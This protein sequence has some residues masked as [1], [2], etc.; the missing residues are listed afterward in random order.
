MFAGFLGWTLDAFDYFL[1]VYCLTVIGREFHRSDAEMAATITATLMFRPLGA[2]LFGL[3]S[4][5]Y[6]R[7]LP[8]IANLV[9]YSAAEVA[10]AFAGSYRTFLILRALFGIGMGGMWGTGASL[11]MEKVPPRLRG[12][13][14]G[15][16]QQGYALGNLLAALAYFFFV[17]RFG[18]RPLF[19]IGGL[20]ALLAIFVRTQIRESEVWEET[21]AATWGHL[22]RSLWANWKVFLYMT[23]LMTFMN[24]SSHGTQDMYPTFLQR[25]WHFD[26]S[27]RSIFSAIASVGALIGG[28]CFGWY[29]D[30]KG[31]RR[32]IVTALLLA[33]AIIPLWTLA[34]NAALLVTGA[35][36]IQFLVQGAWG[37]IPAHLA[38][39][40]PDNVRGFLP[41]FAYQ[42]GVLISSSIGLIQVLVASHLSYA[43]T[44]AMTAGFAFTGGIIV[45][46][47]GKERRGAVFGGRR[48]S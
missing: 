31:R 21:R 44:M 38:E 46:S 42:V 3:L 15:L 22:R 17:D 40:S 41:G 20:P 43:T 45:T 13:L 14:S 18:W 28:V 29:S 48:L 6:G 33:L 9:F 32:A 7:R 1:V 19:V 34:P 39:L 12:L 25:Y 35:F 36:L 37:V 8:M 23:L 4:D 5:R 47:L 30:L 26:A 27:K 11:T 10:T 24:F 2:L 16:L